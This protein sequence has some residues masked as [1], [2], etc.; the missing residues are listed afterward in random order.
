[1]TIDAVPGVAPAE[2]TAV[3]EPSAPPNVVELPDGNSVTL[4]EKVTI[5]L[6]IA[7]LSVIKQG[8]S[9]A[10]IEAGLAQVYLELGIED[11]SYPGPVTPENIERFLPYAAGGLEVAERADAL[12]SETVMRPLVARLAKSL[13]P[14]PT[15]SSTSATRRSGS[16]RP[17]PSGRSSQNGTAGSR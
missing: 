13:Q 12:Y 7:A 8:G 3:P 10:V 9:Q 6:G 16:R 5:P 15:P 14:S 1:M 17:T 2:G 4:R 11:W